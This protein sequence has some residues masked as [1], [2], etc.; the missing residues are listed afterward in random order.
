MVGCRG[1]LPGEGR[2]NGGPR[3]VK[4]EDLYRVSVVNGG[5][6]A[7]MEPGPDRRHRTHREVGG[8]VVR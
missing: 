4:T 5:D 2:D 3:K 8:N 7:V 6:V 1:G